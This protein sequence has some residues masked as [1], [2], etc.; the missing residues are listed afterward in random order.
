MHQ[1][2]TVRE[3]QFFTSCHTVTLHYL[4]FTLSIIRGVILFWYLKFSRIVFLPKWT[5]CLRIWGT[6][7]LTYRR[8]MHILCDTVLLQYCHDSSANSWSNLYG[9]HFCMFIQ[10]PHTQNVDKFEITLVYVIHMISGPYTMKPVVDERSDKIT[11]ILVDDVHTAI[12][13]Y[14]HRVNAC[15]HIQGGPCVPS[16]DA[17]QHNFYPKIKIWIHYFW[18]KYTLI[19][20][21]LIPRLSRMKCKYVFDASSRAIIFL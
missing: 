17:V 18:Y 9:C 15:I 16:R 2:F 6:Y 13:W 8:Q 5:S 10:I 14:F 12:P 20:V 11:L 7:H 19:S 1:T 21:I 4:R 3:H